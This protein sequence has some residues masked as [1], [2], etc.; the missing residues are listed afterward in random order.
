MVAE[1]PNFHVLL[2]EKETLA[3]RPVRAVNT[4]GR[5]VRVARICVWRANLSVLPRTR[6][7]QANLSQNGG[8]GQVG[9][10]II[11]TTIE[12]REVPHTHQCSL[13]T[14]RGKDVRQTTA[15]GC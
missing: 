1:A 3:P 4:N 6:V 11:T 13:A 10:L 14:Y 5:V 15:Q 9:E 7:P 2:I 8:G 12:R